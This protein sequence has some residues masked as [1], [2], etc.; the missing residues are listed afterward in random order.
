NGPL[1]FD[2]LATVAHELGHILGFSPGVAPRLSPIPGS[3]NLLFTGNNGFTAQFAPDQAHLADA[4]HPGDLMTSLQWY[5]QRQ[6]PS[7][8]DLRVLQASYGSSLVTPPPSPLAATTAGVFDPATATF[9]LRNTHSPGAPDAGPFA[10]GGP[11]WRPV[12]GDWDGD[13]RD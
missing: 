5:G 11:G 1:G 9:Y 12:A 2:M 8:T 7:D 6:L 10:Y 3:P 13:G 4:A